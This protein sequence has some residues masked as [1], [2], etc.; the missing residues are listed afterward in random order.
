MVKTNKEGGWYKADDKGYSGETEL[1]E[2][3]AKYPDLIP[4]ED[5]GD[6]R[7]P[8]KV[9]VREADNTDLIGVDEDGNITI[10][11]TKLAYNPEVKR[12]VI[13]QIL[14]YASKLWQS[15]Y[16]D[17]DSTIRN[18]MGEDLQT[19]MGA[20]IGNG[21]EWSSDDFRIAVEENLKEGRFA[22]FIIV[23]A[24]NDEL[25]QTISYINSR[26]PDVFV[27]YALEL[28]YFHEKG[29]GVIL[30]KLYGV[31]ASKTKTKSFGRKKWAKEDFLP[32]ARKQLNKTQ[33]LAIE[34]L[35]KFCEQ[36]ADNLGMGTGTETASI[37]VNFKKFSDERAIFCL[38]SNG[39]LGFSLN[40]VAKKGVSAQQKD[41]LDKL[42]EK[43]KAIKINI[44]DGYDTYGSTW[45][46]VEEATEKANDIIKILT[47]L[48]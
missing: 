44:V 4:I 28:K 24:I 6:D 46:S 34:K 19:L 9:I 3:L 1:Q 33:Y 35:F 5:L 48:I 16:E 21:E 41:L 27:L 17:F 38:K 23:D 2:M 13:G 25:R 31:P 42:K 30:P 18:I 43:L 32:T 29:V 8:I 40:W 15:S 47:D 10:V 26:C 22:L 45:L 36:H 7:K 14:E 37:N 39:R 12:E 11:E 20:E